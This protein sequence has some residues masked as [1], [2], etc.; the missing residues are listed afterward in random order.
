MG[1]RI[2]VLW[3]VR[4]VS[5]VLSFLVA[6][7][8]A[9]QVPLLVRQPLPDNPS[10]SAVRE[11]ISHYQGSYA[12]WGGTIARIEN[13]ED[14]TVLEIV[15]RQLGSEG[16]PQETDVSPGRFLAHIEEFLDPAIYQQ[17]RE[18][19]VYGVI[20]RLVK[21]HIGKHP[22]TFPLVRVKTYYLWQPESPG[23]F[24]SYPVI[25]IDPTP[26]NMMVKGQEEKA[27]NSQKNK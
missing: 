9:G 7:G 14:H 19:T 20:E 5:V 2:R 15:A 25:P 1:E 24:Y 10:I 16:Q 23:R 12:R 21:G 27:T 6:G 18:I 13:K 3:W 8:C 11:D 4:R 22:Y 26:W 17:G